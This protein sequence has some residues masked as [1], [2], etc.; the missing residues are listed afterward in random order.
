MVGSGYTPLHSPPSLISLGALESSEYVVS[1]F[2][3]RQALSRDFP[4]VRLDERVLRDIARIVASVSNR[5]EKLEL[6]ITV[7]AANGRDVFETADP[8]FFLSEDM[9]T[10][11]RAVIINCRH[12][13][14]STECKVSLNDRF[15]PGARVEVKGTDPTEVSGVF[16]ELC[17]VFESRLTGLAWLRVKDPGVT[18]SFAVALLAAVLLWLTA[19]PILRLVARS[20]PEIWMVVRQ[21]SPVTTAA[22]LALCWG[23]VSFP[24]IAALKR[25]FPLVEFAGALSDE[26]KKERRRLVWWSSFVL[27]PL[28]LNIAAGLVILFVPAGSK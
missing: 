3:R 2:T 13:S 21:T 26:G 19:L 24:V 25:A 18:S 20:H 6:N 8:D 4:P 16:G 15:Y 23:F 1:T 11:L 12:Y 5:H 22:L 17:H 10:H 9:P 27:L 14:E 7:I 28:L